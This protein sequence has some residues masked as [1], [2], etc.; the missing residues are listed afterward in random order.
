MIRLD[1]PQNTIVR[2]EEGDLIA[3]E[4]GKGDKASK[5]LY[6]RPRNFPTGDLV[7]VS[8]RTFGEIDIHTEFEVNSAGYLDSRKDLQN[9]L[10]NKY[11][12]E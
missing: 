10:W 1:V 8:A 12:R 9:L 4:D 11:M 7:C 2:L 5:R 6:V 3:V